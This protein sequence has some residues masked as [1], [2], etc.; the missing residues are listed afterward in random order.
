MQF[1]LRTL[2]L[3]VATIAVLIVPL[4]IVL[5]G[6]RSV[7]MGFDR[8][9]QRTYDQIE[10]GESYTQLHEFFGEPRSTES[11]FSPAI[12]YRE[13][14]F[15]PTD[16]SKCVKFVTWNNGGNWFY[17]FGIDENGKIVLKADGNS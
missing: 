3:I 8:S 6:P 1:R 14:E 7:L 13:S 4:E 10:I 16:L 15:S 11:Y 5:R 2:L 9:M 12:A 17:C